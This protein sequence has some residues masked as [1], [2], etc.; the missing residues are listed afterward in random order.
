MKNKEQFNDRIDTL[1]IDAKSLP[2]VHKYTTAHF[3]GL[4]PVF[5]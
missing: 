1:Q 2:T 4:I 5:Q 3:P